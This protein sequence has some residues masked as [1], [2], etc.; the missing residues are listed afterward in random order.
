MVAV[1]AVGGHAL[2]LTSGVVAVHVRT[3]RTRL[4]FWKG[5]GVTIV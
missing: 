3:K 2:A 5:G 4:L 1:E